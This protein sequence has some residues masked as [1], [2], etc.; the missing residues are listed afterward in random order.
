MRT[1]LYD[2]EDRPIATIDEHG[3]IR[4]YNGHVVGELLDGVIAGWNGNGLGEIKNGEIFNAANQAIGRTTSKKHSSPPYRQ[5]L[6]YAGGIKR[7][8]LHG[9]QGVKP[10]NQISNP[11]SLEEILRSGGA[12]KIPPLKFP[13][14]NPTP[15]A[16]P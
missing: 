7:P 6:D 3:V 11:H 13:G 8:Y 1:T 16:Q 15:P 4:L 14:E 9:S 5:D 10:V 2:L 12:H